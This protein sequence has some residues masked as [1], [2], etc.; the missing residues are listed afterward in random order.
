MKFI[1]LDFRRYVDDEDY[2]YDS[3]DG[4]DFV[5]LPPGAN[6]CRGN[7]VI[8]HRKAGDPYSEV[9]EMIFHPSNYTKTRK[10]F[11]RNKQ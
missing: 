2:Y 9:R 7:L 8:N 5:K 11:R 1:F 3:Y 4:S 6:G 10:Q